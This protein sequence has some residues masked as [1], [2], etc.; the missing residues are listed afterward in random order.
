M[1][2]YTKSVFRFE[3]INSETFDL[4]IRVFEIDSQN[5]ALALSFARSFRK[6][7]LRARRCRFFSSFVRSTQ[8]ARIVLI[9]MK[10]NFPFFVG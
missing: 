4:S 9:P 8:N 10:R 2:R 7:T 1:E 6:Q 5:R 3:I